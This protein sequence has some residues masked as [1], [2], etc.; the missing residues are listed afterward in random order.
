M[1]SDYKYFNAEPPAASQS[2]SFKE[3]TAWP[4]EALKRFRVIFKAVQ[5]HSQWVE[6]NCGV[7]SAQ[8]WFMWELL[9][10]PGMRVT[11]IAKAMAIHQSTASNLLEKLVKK[12]LVKRERNCKDQRVV[13]LYLTEAGDETLRQAPLLPARGVLQQALFNLPEEKLVALCGNLDALI[14]KM[15]FRDEQADM[16]PINPLV[17]VAGARE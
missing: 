16:Q 2:V 11:E 4:H 8:F 7:S 14:E 17:I 6:T 12:G 13:S 9:K 15:G 3:S 10:S 1:P 5:N